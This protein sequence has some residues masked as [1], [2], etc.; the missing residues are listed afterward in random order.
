MSGRTTIEWAT[1]TWN[2]IRA[3]GP[4][5]WACSKI[6]DGCDHCYADAFS[7][8][9]GGPGYGRGEHLN[10]P[11]RLD[12]KA[13]EEP[14]HWKK[15]RRIFVCSMTD[16]FH[17]SVRVEW[18]DRILAVAVL[19]PQH[20]YMLLTKRSGRM[21]A[22]ASSLDPRPEV[23]I[24]AAAY[25]MLAAGDDAVVHL[26]PSWPLPNVW[27][28][29]S[30]EAEPFAWRY[31]HL[32]DTP[33]AVR[34]VSAEPLLGPVPGLAEA[35]APAPCPTCGGTVLI[36]PA[37]GGRPIACECRSSPLGAGLVRG[38]LLDWLIVGG[39]SGGPVARSLVERCTAHVLAKGDLNCLKCD[40][41]GLMPK[42]PAL[43]AARE[44]RDAARLGG[45]PFMFKQW[46]GPTHA[47]G[48]RLLDGRTWD[49]Y[50][51]RPAEEETHVRA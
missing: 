44:L 10:V 7:K 45:V 23:G 22:Y 49:D 11:L 3:D 1:H 4:G 31:R 2:P 26:D 43:A 46:G 20:T 18:I 40:G 28:G 6:S 5:K 27:L 25:E 14:L 21:R 13:L 51:G 32:A 9:M 8:R 50:P 36:R 19:A 30:V 16:L 29:V 34:F 35:M 37:E 42:A 38:T 41:S 47:A 39:E 15:P 48:G 33:A 24:A 12:A 17:P